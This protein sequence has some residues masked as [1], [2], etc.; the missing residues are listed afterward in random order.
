M[1]KE[2]EG[3]GRRRERGGGEKREGGWE[4]EREREEDGGVGRG[5]PKTILIKNTAQG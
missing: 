2:K 4:D 3:E 1:R 5:V